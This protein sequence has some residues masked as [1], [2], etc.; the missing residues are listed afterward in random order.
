MKKTVQHCNAIRR[1][2]AARRHYRA[3][4]RGLEA[5]AFAELDIV[6]RPIGPL[7]E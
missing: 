3:L 4:V 1:A 7:A 5:L 2:W 6:E